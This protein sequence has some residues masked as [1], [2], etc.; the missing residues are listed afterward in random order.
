MRTKKEKENAEARFL[1]TTTP[2]EIISSMN[3]TANNRDRILKQLEQL[4]VD[5]A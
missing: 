3:K 2:F 4:G 1:K 5:L